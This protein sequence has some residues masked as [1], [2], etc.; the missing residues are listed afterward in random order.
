MASLLDDLKN[1]Y[2]TRE[3]A[4]RNYALDESGIAR[5]SPSVLA[6][7]SFERDEGLT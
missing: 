1:G 3:Q 5:K 2:V 4:I 6:F 7:N